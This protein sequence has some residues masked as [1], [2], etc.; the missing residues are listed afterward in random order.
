MEVTDLTAELSQNMG[1]RHRE[2]V[3]VTTV[4]EGRP[5][6][7]AFAKAMSS[8]RSIAERVRT[9]KEYHSAAKGAG[10]PLLAAHFPWRKHP[11]RGFEAIMTH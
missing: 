2:G 8:W 10:H 7:L 11:V 9:A 5:L 1:L 3:V 6:L 4:E